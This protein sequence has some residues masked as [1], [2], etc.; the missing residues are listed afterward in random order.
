MV[1]EYVN[2]SRHSLAVSEL[3]RDCY[4]ILCV[5]DDVIIPR[6]TRDQSRRV[7]SVTS[8]WRLTGARMVAVVVTV[9]NRGVAGHVVRRRNE[10]TLSDVASH[11]PGLLPSIRRLKRTAVL[12]VTS[13]APALT[14]SHV[15]H[16]MK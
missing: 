3:Q 4:V 16:N 9:L 12:L 14:L 7:T 11:W 15:I 6:D 13:D 2:E 1:S 10:A 5:T 8:Q